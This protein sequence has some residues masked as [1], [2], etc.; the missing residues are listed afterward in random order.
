[1]GEHDQ[2]IQKLQRLSHNFGR[3]QVRLFR[4]SSHLLSHFLIKFAFGFNGCSPAIQVD[5][6]LLDFTGTFINHSD[7]HVAFDFLNFIIVHITIATQSLNSGFRGYI[8]GFRRKIFSNRTFDQNIS[9]AR[10]HPL[11]NFL[12]ICLRRG[13][14]DDIRYQQFMRIALLINQW[15]P[16]LNSRFGELDGFFH[17]RKPSSESECRH[18]QPR[19]G[20][21]II[22]LF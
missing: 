22:S 11:G 12:D 2:V 18:H 19:I 1:M 5:N 14:T 10:I 13:Q 7:A 16:K 8:S 15:R 3:F 17:S 4:N 20:K 9:I 6:I 21:D